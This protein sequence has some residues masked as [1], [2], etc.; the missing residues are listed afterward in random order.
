MY[1]QKQIVSVMRCAIADLEGMLPEIDPSGNREHSGWKTLDELNQWVKILETHTVMFAWSI[2]DVQS[3]REDL[4]DEQAFEVLV[5]CEDGHDAS[6]GMNWDT[7]EIV[8][9]QMFPIDSEDG[10]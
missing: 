5:G 1:T 3:V 7:I 8:A 9:D 6:I 2:E 4:N 10:E